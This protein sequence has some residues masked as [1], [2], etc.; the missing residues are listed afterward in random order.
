MGSVG[1]V[2]QELTM[3]I[4]NGRELANDLARYLNLS[5]NLMTWTEVPLG[6]GGSDRADVIAVAKSFASKRF[7]IY[8]V[9]ISRSDFLHDVNTNKYSKYKEHCHQLYF[10]CPSGLIKK[11]EVPSDCGLITQK[12]DNW[13]VIKSAPRNEFKPTTNLLIRLLL[14]GYE[15]YFSEYRKIEKERFTDSVTLVD[16]ARKQGIKIAYELAN[17]QEIIEEANKYK[18]DYEKVAGKNFRTLSD[19]V[20]NMRNELN[21]LLAKRTYAVEA[22]EL[23]RICIN[24]FEGYT[25]FTN[26]YPEQLRKIA[27]KLEKKKEL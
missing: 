25:L 19:A 21:N 27:D 11:D 9:K 1:N 4:K 13:R 18:A 3:D 26:T 2:A 7:L 14:R 17:A 12:G 16:L 23:S 22:I 5:G 6:E 10:A 15:N 20:I 8:E 24:M